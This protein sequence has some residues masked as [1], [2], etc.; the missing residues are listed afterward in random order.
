MPASI[1]EVIAACDDQ[2]MTV[3]Q[4]SQVIL[5]DQSLTANLLKLANSAFYGHARRVTTATE[6]VVLLGFSAIKSLAISSPHLAPAERGPARL[7]PAAGR[8]LAPLDR[9]GLHRPAARRRGQARAG[10]GGVRRRPAA[11]HRQDDPLRL[12]GERLRRGHPDRPGAAHAV[13]RGRD[14]AARASTT[15]SSGAQVAAAWSFPPE[16]E[17]AIRYHHSPHEARLKPAL[18]HC[19]HLA[20]AAC[21]MLGVGLGVDGM[22]YAIDP[23]SLAVL[24]V[25]AD[26]LSGSWRTSR[27][28]MT[29]DALGRLMFPDDLTTAVLTQRDGRLQ[30]PQ[31]G[32]RQQHRQRRH[33]RLQ[34]GGRLVR[35]G[36]GRR[37]ERRPRAPE[38]GRRQLHLR[39][40]RRPT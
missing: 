5:R 3:G 10:R 17:E 38:D 11:R 28:L 33:A 12:H 29:G 15:P 19:V 8:A 34:A 37:G 27:P 24:G 20:D 22:M 26:R 6:A 13:P 7:R 2:D 39:D 36:A 21:M 30:R 40:R 16:L 1:S 23:D 14:R 32:D 4:L 31:H 25:D 9:R 18:A 35:V